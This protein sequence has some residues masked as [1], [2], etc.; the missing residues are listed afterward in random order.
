[1]RTSLN[2]SWALHV[3]SCTL[4]FSGLI[5][6]SYIPITQLCRDRCWFLLRLRLG[7]KNKAKPNCWAEKFQRCYSFSRQKTS[8]LSQLPVEELKDPLPPPWR[9]YMSPQGRR[10]YVNTTNN[11][12]SID[13]NSWADIISNVYVNV[14]HE[15]FAVLHNVLCPAKKELKQFCL[16][17]SHLHIWK[18]TRSEQQ[19]F[20]FTLW[21]TFI[22]A[23]LPTCFGK[24]GYCHYSHNNK[25]DWS[26]RRLVCLTSPSFAS[27]FWTLSMVVLTRFPG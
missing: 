6:L 23:L 17:C 24:S 2:L 3:S 12:K 5:S 10:Y 25:S 7:G 26:V 16:E 27:P 15:L 22:S 4:V 11:G 20:F 13:L 9:C 19:G 1:M 8:S 18:V 14:Y 21:T